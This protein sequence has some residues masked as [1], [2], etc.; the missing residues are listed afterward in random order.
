MQTVWNK[1]VMVE[2]FDDPTL[3]ALFK[4]KIKKEPCRRQPA[5]RSIMDGAVGYRY[6]PYSMS[7][8]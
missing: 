7:N 2:T 1:F 3:E 5:H 8:K 6:V 4:N